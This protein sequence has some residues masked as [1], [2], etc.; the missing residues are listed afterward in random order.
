MIENN[1]FL[2]F[3]VIQERK[4][5]LV[6]KSKELSKIVQETQKESSKLKQPPKKNLRLPKTWR[7]FMNL[8]STKNSLTSS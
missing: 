1:F 4:R 6:E 8:V 2:N 7:R 3:N 5:S